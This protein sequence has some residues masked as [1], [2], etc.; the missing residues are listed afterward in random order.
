MKGF[1]QIIKEYVLPYKGF[2]GLNILF[3]TLGVIASLLSLI[4]IGP[5]LQV[6]F[7]S[8]EILTDPV[9]WTLS[10]D[11]LSHNFNYLIGQQIQDYGS[12]KALLLVSLL[13]I[14]M[15]FLKTAN[16]FLA[17]Y[18]MAPIRN[19]VVRDIR[20]K[21]YVKMLNLPLS[22]FSE[23][24]K[25][26]IMARV[27]QDV[28]EIEWSVMASLEK[29]F[30]DPINI[31]VFLIGLLLISPMLTLFV[32]ILL[33]V[34]AII[35]G[36]IGKN[37]RK[38]ST[39]GQEQMGGLMSMLEETISGLRIIKAF[40]AQDK[41]EQGFSDKN[42]QYT[43]TMNQI[44]R[45]RYLASPLSEFM[46]AIV[47]VVLLSFGGNMVLNGSSPLGAAS[48][49][50]Y[51]AI[52]SQLM[53]PAK[54]FSTAFYHIQKGLASFDRVDEI[55][56]VDKLIKNIEKPIAINSFQSLIEYK[57]ITFSYE[58]KPVLKDVSL[59]IKKGQ[60]V[61]LVGKSGSGKSTFVDLLPR[62]YDVN[63]GEI[64]VD[65]VNIKELN[66]NQL[67][68]LQGYVHQEAILFNDSFA[69]NIAFGLDKTDND[70]LWEAAKA[71]RADDFIR[72]S[73]DGMNWIIGDRGGKLSGGQKQR[74]SIAR[75]LYA[76]PEILILDEA[77]SSLDTESEREVQQ[78]LKELMKNRT[79]L[80][81][82]HRLSTII[83]ADQIVVFKDGRIVEQGTHQQLI[84]KKG[85]YL[86]LYQEI[87]EKEN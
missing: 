51:I 74:I 82:A 27:T 75:A 59:S 23:E 14:I 30:R 58:E 81:V 7:G 60:T 12:Q 61:A 70:R 49:M 38:T 2:V 39:K 52:F 34:S 42:E 22:F 62:F 47:I 55:L 24:R 33:P 84:D 31:L 78:A 18:F 4:L 16:V 15:F 36:Q 56:K 46:G 77:T 71:A 11:A 37:L 41:M 87:N 64:L 8:Q 40:N 21:L 10:K 35:I 20:N 19:G 65:N 72:D 57:N 29:F 85:E 68:K 67:R 69:A 45:K 83:Q 6:L 17:N 86:S 28:Q 32:L 9:P 50:A 79:T 54:S 26:D 76:N 13:I 53:T 63:N 1:W 80:I 43:K 5:F 44:T 66:I 73:P 3:N 25:G 48:F